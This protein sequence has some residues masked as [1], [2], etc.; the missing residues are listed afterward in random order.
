MISKYLFYATTIITMVLLFSSCNQADEAQAAVDREDTFFLLEKFFEAEEKRLQSAN[1]GLDKEIR[2]NEKE[3]QQLIADIDYSRE[4][5]MF[6]KADINR[7]AW[8]DKYQA[9]STLQQGGLEIKYTSLDP[10]LKTQE[11]FVMMNK[12]GEVEKIDIVSQTETALARNKSWMT[13]EPKV[14]YLIKTQ[15]ENRTAETLNIEI[16]GRFVAQ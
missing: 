16:K 4:F 12:E 1:I 6:R 3:E 13:Y 15:Q 8:S 11:L 7:P 10:E 5:S 2:I 14:G 9:D